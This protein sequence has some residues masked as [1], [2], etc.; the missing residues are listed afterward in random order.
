MFKLW[1][2]VFVEN[3]TAIFF[4]ENANNGLYIYMRNK[5]VAVNL[6]KYKYN[7]NIKCI[8]LN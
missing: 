2:L 7:Y 6:N 3:C 1:F 5:W 4:I 8:I